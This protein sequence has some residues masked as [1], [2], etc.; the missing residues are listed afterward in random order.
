[1]SASPNDLDRVFTTVHRV[2]GADRLELSGETTADDIDGWDSVS[3]A[4]LILEL[5]TEFKTALSFEASVAL[6]NL[7]ELANY[8]VEASRAAEEDFDI[9]LAS[10]SATSSIERAP[11]GDDRRVVIVFG[12]C[13]AEAIAGCLRQHPALAGGEV[14]V[15]LS[16][17]MP[18]QEP[19]SLPPEIYECC[20]MLWEQATPLVRFPHRDKLPI[21]CRI[22]TYPSIDFN[23]LWP[24]N[25]PEP[26]NHPQA[27]FPFGPFSYGD[28][29]INEIVESGLSG[30]AAWAAYVERSLAAMPNLHRLADIEYSRWTTLERELDVKLADRVFQLF[31]KE[32]LFYTFNHPTPDMLCHVGTEL[33]RVSGLSGESDYQTLFDEVRSLFTWEFGRDYEVPIHPAVANAFDL[34]W[35]SPTMH[36]NWHNEPRLA[37]DFI[38]AQLD[39]MTDKN[40]R[41][42]TASAVG[43]H[44]A[45]HFEVD[46]PAFKG[47][48]GVVPPDSQVAVP[49]EIEAAPEIGGKFIIVDQNALAVGGH[50]HAYTQCIASAAIDLGMEVFVLYN[51]KFKGHWFPDRVKAIAAFDYSWSE[52]EA[53]WQTNW[54]QG[55][56]AYDFFEATRAIELG[57]HDHVFFSTIGYAELYNVLNH[58]AESI[59]ITPTCHYHILLRYDPEILASRIMDFVG[60]FA[61]INRGA[62]LRDYVHFHSDT[63]GL[64]GAFTDLLGVPFTTLPIP[65]LQQPL[66]TALTAASERSATPLVIAYLGDARLEKNYNLIPDAVAYLYNKYVATGKIRFVI[67]SNFNVPGGEPGILASA[68]RLGQYLPEQVKLIDNALDTDNYYKILADADAIIIPYDADR[69]R[70]RSSGILVEAMAA[71]KPIVTTSNSWMAT[72]VTADH[73]ILLD[74]GKPL[75]PAIE[76]LILNFDRFRQAAVTKAANAMLNSSGASFVHQMLADTRRSLPTASADIPHVLYILDGDVLVIRNGAGVTALTQ[77][78]YLRDAG[79]RITALFLLNKHFQ[80]AADLEEWTRKLKDRVASFRFEGFFIAAPSRLSPS[81]LMQRSRRERFDFSILND[82]EGAV[83]RDVSIDLVKYVNSSKFDAIWLNYIVNFPLVEHLGLGGVPVIGETHDIQSFQK[84]IYGKK[85]VQDEDLQLEF[86]LLSRCSYLISVSA[87]ETAYILS[88]LPGTKVATTGIFPDVRKSPLRSLAGPKSIGE[89]LSSCGPDNVEYQWEQAW[90]SNRTDKILRLEKVETLDLVFVSSNHLANVSGLKWFLETIYFPYLAP[91]GVSLIVAGSICDL[92]DWPQHDKLFFVGRL[93]E[94]SPLYAAAR[95]VVLPILEGAGIAVKTQEALNHGRPVVATSI[96]IR[97]LAAG[98]D[99]VIEA[100]D[101][102]DF[103]NAVNDLL[104]SDDKR[105]QLGR[106]AYIA[107]HTVASP[108]RYADIL[109]P[110]FADVLGARARHVVRENATEVEAVS[111]LDWCS[112][113]R[114]ANRAIRN[115][116]NDHLIEYHSLDEFGRHPRAEVQEVLASLLDELVAR[117]SAFACSTEASMLGKIVTRRRSDAAR[118]LDFFMLQLDAFQ[119]TAPTALHQAEDLALV[120]STNVPFQLLVLASVLSSALPDLRPN[121]FAAPRDLGLENVVGYL[122]SR[123]ADSHAASALDLLRLKPAAPF[124]KSVVL[125]ASQSFN[126]LKPNAHFSVTHSPNGGSSASSVILVP[127][128]NLS[129]NLPP[130]FSNTAFCVF[131]DLVVRPEPVRLQVVASQQV[132]TEECVLQYPAAFAHRYRV[133]TGATAIDLNV[134]SGHSSLVEVRRHIVFGS[135]IQETEVLLVCGSFLG[136]GKAIDASS[137]RQTT[138]SELDDGDAGKGRSSSWQNGKQSRTGLVKS[139][140]KLKDILSDLKPS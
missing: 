66:K 106:A 123:D 74:S 54:D 121:D 71:G 101:P 17:Q 41:I 83:H 59:G 68:Q 49:A 113:V 70:L 108:K 87:A 135:A 24:L 27:G 102:S 110:V 75:G 122:L 62:D 67:Q 38:Q 52:A 56:I 53:R 3:H 10:S 107:A 23:L 19:P 79:Y 73:A 65:F 137:A 140:S 55:N 1:M 6:A 16:F 51:R 112:L 57:P 80:D 95:L 119:R 86:A 120:I 8:I 131:V 78:D 115:W 132:V 128:K 4:N 46:T 72:Q 29:I 58:I 44:G 32:R 96:A 60:P 9:A 117:R 104:K 105:R 22:S 136:H 77:L 116:L 7:R 90:A 82:V 50:Y 130:H 35:W 20:G 48:F 31:R 91:S 103:A 28:R 15:Y 138:L 109:N 33:L 85:R 92:T 81:T 64:S 40:E 26:R 43:G 21:D 127:G 37:K 12:N 13:Q 111:L 76:R 139:L 126:P 124:D 45:P 34:A 39:W 47:E 84:S 5:E 61:R 98:L 11:F 125:V 89:I 100:N 18:G 114:H 129:I 97:G 30:E 14:H 94:L 134:V 88:R 93:Q 99:G 133:P 36:Y 69:Y 42:E 2:F 63:E 25:A 118:A